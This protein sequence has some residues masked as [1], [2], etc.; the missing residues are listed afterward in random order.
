MK[1]SFNV[2]KGYT[3]LDK[4]AKEVADRIT[5]SLSEVEQLEDKGNDIVIEIENK[6]L[7]HRP[8]CFSHLGIAREV[9]AYFNVTCDDPLKD[10]SRSTYP[11]ENSL[12]LTI[13]IE[14]KELTLRYTA[15]VLSGITVGPSPKWL[16]E[17]LE[18][19]GIRSINNVVDLTN[20]VMIDLGQPL[21]AFDYDKVKDHTIKVRKAKAGEKL[22]TLDGKERELTE[23]MLVIADSK[24]P[25]GLAGIMGGAHTEVTNETKTIIV[26]AATFEAK[27]NRKTSKALNLRTDA[28]TRFE[29]GLDPNL[30]LPTIIRFI[31]MLKEHT[32]AT[33]SSEIYDIY[34]EKRE[35]KVI[36]VSS[37]WINRFLGTTF[38][39]EEMGNF[40][41][42][43]NFK[44]STNNSDIIVTI[45]TYRS[46]L[47]MDA[48]I[49]E[50]IARVYGYDN[51]PTTLPS[52]TDFT[53]KKN[54]DLYWRSRIR[55][56]LAGM[57]FYENVTSPFI[58]MDLI[59]KSKLEGEVHLQLKNPLTNEQEYM[60]RN[61]LPQLLENVKKNIPVTTSMRLYEIN[62][63]FVPQGNDQPREPFYLTGITIGDDY[64]TVKGFVETIFSKLGITNYSFGR[65]PRKDEERCGFFDNLF[66]PNKTAQIYNANSDTE[67]WGTIGY[68]HPL[69]QKNF[70]IEG[71]LISFDIPLEM[72]VKYAVATKTYQPISPYPPVIEDITI[73]IQEKEQR[74]VGS[75]IEKMKKTSNLI[76]NIELTD[77]FNNR[78]TF[79]ITF[80][81]SKRNLTEKEVGEIK[82]QIIKQIG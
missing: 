18:N 52:Q 44:V 35:E 79:R 48:D 42:R 16:K 59:K 81:D 12:P 30:P 31:R 5:L 3:K 38:S 15:V 70:D 11:V 7:T 55:T 77:R 51:I 45:P 34:T 75:V 4:T 41:K 76:T 68:I 65:Y 36:T 10:L 62:K 54:M 20:F 25:I 58:G 23:D 26:E 8:D 33:V 43:F 14:A 28:A 57:G 13:E 72:L 47:T 1:L 37:K 56:L 32:D 29:K 78:Y 69:V 9:A 71:D 73:D 27:N 21:H 22:I 46:D 24:N 66:H 64:P 17:T 82:E 53:P 74:T 6:A 19:I 60:R 61:L 80:Q 67:I 49:A 2:L 63:L 40:L 50:E 39:T